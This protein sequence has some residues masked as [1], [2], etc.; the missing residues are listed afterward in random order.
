MEYVHVRFHQNPSI[1]SWDE[2]QLDTDGQTDVNIAAC[3]FFFFA[4]CKEH[5]IMASVADGHWRRY[6]YIELL[7]VIGLTW[8]GTSAWIS[9]MVLVVK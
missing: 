7:L 9:I 2:M 8:C 1:N 6:Y 4:L 5:A 3:I